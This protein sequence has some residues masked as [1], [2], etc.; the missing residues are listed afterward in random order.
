MANLD[1]YSNKIRFDDFVKIYFKILHAYRV[2]KFK[3]KLTF[4]IFPQNR[5]KIL[6]KFL[7]LKLGRDENKVQRGPSMTA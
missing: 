3:K 7:P 1:N 4:N 6:L 2:R 5:S